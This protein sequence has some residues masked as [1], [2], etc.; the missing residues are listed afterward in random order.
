MPEKPQMFK[1]RG[2]RRLLNR[3]EYNEHILYRDAAIQAIIGSGIT[4]FLSVYLV[5]LGSSD[6]LVG[7]LTSL[8][9]LLMTIAALPAAAFIQRKGDLVKAVNGGRA[10]F[11]IGI[12]TFSILPFLSAAISPY[13]LV[14]GRSLL[15][16]ATAVGN[17]SMTTILGAATTERR[18]A[19]MLSMRLAVNGLSAAVV[20][21]LAG[22][23]LDWL[24]TP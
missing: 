11:R 7:L 5:R 15:S 20:G 8:P 18:R 19:N 12:S 9:A 22:Q 13:L 23:W 17:V 16:G 21:F 6:M 3:D 4:A 14:F 24:P 10:V 2:I 1:L